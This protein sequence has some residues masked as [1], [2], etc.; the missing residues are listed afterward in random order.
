LLA[1]KPILDA[2]TGFIYHAERFPLEI[3]R[4]WLELRSAEDEVSTP[5]VGLMFESDDYIKPGVNLEIS[6]SVQNRTEN[7][8]GRVVLVRHNGDH[9]EVGLWLQN[10]DDASRLR[11]VEQICHI[12]AYTQEKKYREGP[13]NLNPDKVAEEWIAKYASEVPSL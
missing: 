9:Y 7:F 5:Q 4:K 13:Y 12:E 10:R 11:I 8:S 2:Q 3:K 6:I 1:N